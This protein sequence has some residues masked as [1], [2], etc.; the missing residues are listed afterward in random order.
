MSDVSLEFW[1]SDTCIANAERLAAFLSP[2]FEDDWSDYAAK[3]SGR[4][5]LS[6][7]V[8][9][10]AD[11]QIIGLKMGYERNRCVFNSWIGGV[12]PDFRGQGLATRLMEAQHEWAKAAGFRGIETATRQHNRAM[13]IVNFK[14]GFIVAGLDVVPGSETKV[15]F[16]KDLNADF[17]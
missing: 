12:S 11:A 5:S 2:V 15:I 16:Y 13:G 9:L 8:A 6:A 1:D 14:G 17:G 10:G 7:M 4:R 3:L